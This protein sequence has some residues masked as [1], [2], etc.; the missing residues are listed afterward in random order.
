[1]I[2]VISKCS[3]GLK[4][5]TGEVV[6]RRHTL[7]ILRIG[8]LAPTPILRPRGRFEIASESLF[9]GNGTQKE[10]MQGTDMNDPRVGNLIF[11]EYI[12]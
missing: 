7:S 2:E 5:K 1:M 11:S 8:H 3:I 10:T 4:I 12:G 6:N 9:L